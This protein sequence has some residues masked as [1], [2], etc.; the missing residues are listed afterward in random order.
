MWLEPGAYT[1]ELRSSN[2]SFQKRIYVLCG[3]TLS[4]KPQFKE[5][6]P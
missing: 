1:L 5:Q 3:K 2:G 4:I 6:Q